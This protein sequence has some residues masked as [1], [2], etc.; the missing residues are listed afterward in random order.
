MSGAV[1]AMA[2]LLFGLSL[3]GFCVGLVRA[4]VM[5]R[6]AALVVPVGGLATVYL[7]PVFWLPAL[8]WLVLGAVVWQSPPVESHEGVQNARHAGWP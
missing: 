5:P 6:W 2:S 4:G 8:A 3:I 7:S 1:Q